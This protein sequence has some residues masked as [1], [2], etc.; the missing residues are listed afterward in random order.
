[1][2][3]FLWIL[4]ALG[5]LAGSI[6]WVLHTRSAADSLSVTYTYVKPERRD[7]KQ[8]VVING[9]ITPILSTEIR[10][11]VS[12]R[13]ARVLVEA[14]AEVT[15][16]QPLIELDQST[17]QVQ[18]DD[19]RLGV[20]GSR[21]RAERAELEFKR[22]QSL[23]EKALV[24]E[25]ER[26]EAEIALRLAENDTASQEARVR[27]LE[28]SLAKGVITAPYA[29]RVLSL[30]ARPGMIVTGADAGREGNTLLELADLTRL[31]VETA[32]NEIDVAVLT[33]DMPVEITFESVPE[34]K[35]TGRI[36][37]IAPA[38]GRSA[39]GATTT[40]G[41]S[42][43]GGNSSRDFPLQIAI[44]Q[45]HPRV[46]P[47]MTARVHIV[48]ATVSQA[49]SVPQNAVFN[50]HATGD[51]FVFVRAADAKAEPVKT[52]VEL[53]IRDADHVELKSDLSETA[54]VSLQRP[55]TVKFSQDK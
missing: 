49:L 6:G 54:E 21:L 25:K 47:G 46:R 15:K 39:G 50:D 20:V 1:M 28:N 52:K 48:T 24:T 30:A 45:S 11:E 37:F 3:R 27:L 43:G 18:L 41:G 7:L 40:G 33:A 34:A 4:L 9:T 53:G 22:L 23:S 38:A 10:S 51:W 17:L 44:D 8:T 55:P 32:I 19:A 31:R 13:I 36:T 42:G 14:G 26:K 29:G 35:A 12:G 2:K 16:G 5:L